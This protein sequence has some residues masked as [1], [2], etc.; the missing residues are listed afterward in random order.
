LP[1][2]FNLRIKVHISVNA[3]VELRTF[4][5]SYKD[6]V[7]FLI[8]D[9]IANVIQQPS[10]FSVSKHLE[11]IKDEASFSR[12]ANDLIHLKTVLCLLST[13]TNDAQYSGTDLDAF[14]V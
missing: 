10:N 12:S 9:K 11:D 13:V 6:C 8:N 3:S 14:P 5:R 7:N 4:V 1:F 2:S